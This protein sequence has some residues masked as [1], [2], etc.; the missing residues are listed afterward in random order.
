MVGPQ[1]ISS[2]LNERKLL[3]G[4]NILQIKRE[5]AIRNTTKITKGM[6]NIDASGPLFHSQATS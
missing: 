4:G 2:S 1:S 6:H 5:E 3:G